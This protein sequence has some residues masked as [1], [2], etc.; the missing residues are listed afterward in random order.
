MF[1]W[2][3]RKFSNT[4]R[5]E[6]EQYITLMGLLSEEELGDLYAMV[7]FWRQ[8]YR[9]QG[10]DLETISDWIEERPFFPKEIGD[11]IR[12][13][14][15]EGRFPQASGLL[16]WLFTVRAVLYPELEDT[17]LRIWN[18]LTKAPDSSVDKANEFIRVANSQEEVVWKIEEIT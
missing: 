4:Q 16:V 9:R 15:K 2:L 10:V 1:K 14:Q 11:I 5:K 3:D 18:Y 6:A 12:R 13:F 7:L 17:A 8:A